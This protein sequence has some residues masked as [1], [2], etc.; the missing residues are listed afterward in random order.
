MSSGA[1]D[2]AFAGAEGAADGATGAESAA[3]GVGGPELPQPARQAQTRP[4]RNSWLDR[5]PDITDD[6]PLCCRNAST[7]LLIARAPSG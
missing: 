1:A 4:T 7:R 2:G 5:V 3:D 6:L